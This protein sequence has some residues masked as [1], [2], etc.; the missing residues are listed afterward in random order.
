MS[1]IVAI[2]NVYKG[3]EMQQIVSTKT[4]WTAPYNIEHYL[5]Y[6]MLGN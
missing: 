5:L 1:R 6:E 3:S 4:K 2:A